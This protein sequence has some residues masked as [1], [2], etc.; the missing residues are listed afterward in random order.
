MRVT[1]S[2]HCTNHEAAI[3]CIEAL[4]EGVVLAMMEEIAEAP[5]DSFPCCIKCGGFRTRS[6][7]RVPCEHDSLGDLF[8]GGIDD[9]HG[10]APDSDADAGDVVR[11]NIAQLRGETPTRRFTYPRLR[12]RSARE[13]RDSGGG[14][15]IEL[16][17]YQ[18]AQKR[19]EGA[20]PMARV[21][22]VSTIP[23]CFRGVCLMSTEHKK[24]ERRGMIDDPIEDARPIGGCQCVMGGQ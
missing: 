4:C 13:I 24:P 21:V 14:N 7:E 6:S 10:I 11:R 22:I 20:D 12:I 18:T 5:E 16:A 9:P 8:P 17:C 15:T 3:R 23:G 19:L 2:S 1:F